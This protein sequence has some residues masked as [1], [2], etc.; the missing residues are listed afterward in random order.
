LTFVSESQEKGNDEASAQPVFS[1]VSS[2]VPIVTSVL[3]PDTA[4][5]NWVIH[6]FQ[7]GRF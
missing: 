5:T 1:R 3:V 7:T 2:W 4:A 6:S